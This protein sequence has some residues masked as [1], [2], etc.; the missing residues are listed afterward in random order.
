LANVYRIL[1]EP[2]PGTLSSFAVQPFWPLLGV[3]LGG[4]WLSWPWFVF[5]AFAIGSPTR[6]SETGIAAIGFAGNV[7]L[8]IV[9]LTLLGSD[10]LPSTAVPYLG[11]VL[12]VWKIGISY[13]LFVKQTR[14]FGIYEYYGGAV[15][16]GVFV[17]VLAYFAM[18]G[19]GG[20][21]FEAA[22]LLRL[23]MG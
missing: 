15:R 12:V 6:R 13:W 5:N 3:M 20:P 1:D 14:T 19:L 11:L 10:V 16:N 22:P 4:A 18:R 2:Q 7:V 21:L 8:S 23:V 9:L 17:L